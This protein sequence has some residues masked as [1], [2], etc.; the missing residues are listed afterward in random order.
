[1]TPK[2]KK[3]I[4]PRRSLSSLTAVFP[5][6]RSSLSTMSFVLKK[7]KGQ[8]VRRVR[9]HAGLISRWTGS[10]KQSGLF[11]KKEQIEA[12]EEPVI[13][14][15]VGTNLHVFGRVFV[16]QRR[17]TVREPKPSMSGGRGRGTD[18]NSSWVVKT[19]SVK[20]ALCSESGKS[21]LWRGNWKGKRGRR[22]LDPAEALL[23]ETGDSREGDV[24]VQFDHGEGRP[25][26][27][28]RIQSPQQF[29]FLWDLNRK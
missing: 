12:K 16:G 23:T 25:L 10:P 28:L 29:R 7:L 20:K 4:P 21:W 5:I 9:V 17:Q 27:R 8:T 11:R 14:H 24:I 2:G 15:R 19:F 13:Q 26:A 22:H 3:G 1:M 18:L 6:S